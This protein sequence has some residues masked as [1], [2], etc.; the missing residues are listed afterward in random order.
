MLFNWKKKDQ[1][2]SDENGAGMRYVNPDGPKTVEKDAVIK[3][4]VFSAS[5]KWARQSQSIA[6]TLPKSEMSGW[7]SKNV[8]VT[9]DEIAAIVQ[10]GQVIEVVE[11]GKVRVGGLLKTDSYFKD[12]EVVMMDTSPKDANWQVGELWT[13]DQHEVAAKGLLRYRIADPKK[14]FTMVYAYSRLDDKGERFLSLEDINERIKSEVLTRV[15][16]PEASSVEVEEIYGNRELQLKIENELELQLKQTLDM[17][18]LELLKFTS[19]WDLGDYTE[20]A[21]ARRGFEKEEELKELDTLVKEGDYERAGRVGM[22]DV[23]S[24]H[25]VKSEVLEFGR[26]QKVRDVETEVE[27]TQKES[28]SDF[29]EAKRGIETYK[30]WKQA[31]VESKKAEVGIDQEVADKEHAREIERLR[32]ITE[33]GGADAARVI[34]EGREY[35]RLSPAQIEAIA[36]ARESEA[37]AKEDKLAFMKE[38][39]DRERSD[40]YRRQELDA[41]L[42][43]A[44]KPAA[45][46]ASVRKCP[47]CGATV[48]MQASFCGECG[49]KLG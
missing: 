33:K 40:A 28:E 31:K 2:K 12:V 18:G 20:L 34:A 41:K 15:L 16:Q 14:F 17:W 29:E 39:E 23:R 21:K 11:S 5:Y 44:A 22:A 8:V 42:M 38:I 10:D 43:G 27:V 25:A 45:S 1:E 6:R 3:K 30:L 19:E 47:H 26:R 48:P 32:L 7:L 9:P 35:S 4:G 49:S 37:R 13:N 36:K 24:Q 46:G